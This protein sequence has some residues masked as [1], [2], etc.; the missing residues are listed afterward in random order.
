MGADL[1]TVSTDTEFVHLAWHREEKML[2]GVK[3]SMGSDANGKLSRLFGIYDEATGLALRGAYIINPAG[4]LMNAEVNYY[5][6]GRNV[7]ELVR[8]FKANLYLS[9]KTKEGCP[10]KWKEEGDAT[11]KPSAELVGRVYEALEGQQGANTAGRRV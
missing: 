4:V 10:S 11:L 2:K 8:K 7:D 1:V 5:N 6:L 3:Y 9:R